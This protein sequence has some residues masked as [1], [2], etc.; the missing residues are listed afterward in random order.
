MTTVY[1][2][3]QRSQTHFLH[4]Y[5]WSCEHKADHHLTV[6]G[7]L[8]DS[9]SVCTVLYVRMH[10]CD[11]FKLN[12]NNIIWMPVGLYRLGECGVCV[13]LRICYKLMTERWNETLKAW[14]DQLQH[15]R[16]PACQIP[17]FWVQELDSIVPD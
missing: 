7:L 10:V 2:S 3:N 9:N 13:L 1:I 14:G 8:P 5:Q 11:C 6:L 16:L 15:I 12:V 17:L 4:S